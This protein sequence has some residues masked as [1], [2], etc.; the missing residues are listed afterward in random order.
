MDAAERRIE[1]RES[2]DSN[3]AWCPEAEQSTGG[4]L[5]IARSATRRADAKDGVRQSNQGSIPVA[6]AP[7]RFIEGR[8][9]KLRKVLG[10]RR[11]SNLQEVDCR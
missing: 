2:K 3:G 11:R 9:S 6:D 4:R 8:E 1:G 7:E 5:Q 10:A